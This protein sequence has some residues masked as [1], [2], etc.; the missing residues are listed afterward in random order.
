VIVLE[1]TTPAKFICLM[2]TDFRTKPLNFAKHF[3]QSPLIIR[4]F[5]AKGRVLTKK[6]MLCLNLQK[7]LEYKA[8]DIVR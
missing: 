4:F 3:S 1:K 8:I 2:P 5:G 7:K 6:E